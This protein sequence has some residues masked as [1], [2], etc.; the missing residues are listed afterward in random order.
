MQCIS[1]YMSCGVH[2]TSAGSLP[3]VEFTSF[4]H[5]KF[6]ADQGQS[7]DDDDVGVCS[8]TC[9]QAPTNTLTCEKENTGYM[10]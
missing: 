5:E 9:A 10:S 7:H 2:G 6:V 4:Q 3:R 1:F 8:E